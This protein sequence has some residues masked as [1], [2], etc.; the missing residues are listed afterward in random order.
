MA[1][2]GSVEG[3]VYTYDEENI[4]LDFLFPETAGVTGGPVCSGWPKTLNHF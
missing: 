1:A 4:Y 2:D 3:A